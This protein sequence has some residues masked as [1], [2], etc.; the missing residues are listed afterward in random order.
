MLQHVARHRLH[1]YVILA[2]LL[3]CKACPGIEFKDE[4]TLIDHDFS[5]INLLR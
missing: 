4:L 5:L 3:P 1:S 2:R